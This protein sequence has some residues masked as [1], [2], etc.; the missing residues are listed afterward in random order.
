MIARM[1]A[2]TREQPDA[3]F[4]QLTGIFRNYHFPEMKQKHKDYVDSLKDKAEF[5]RLL[6]QLVLEGYPIEMYVC[7]GAYRDRGLLITMKNGLLRFYNNIARDILF[8]TLSNVFFSED[9]LIELSNSFRTWPKLELRSREYLQTINFESR[10]WIRFDGKQFDPF[11]SKITNACW[12]RFMKNYSRLD[13]AYVEW[14]DNDW[15][16][17]L[18]QASISSF[19]EHNRDFTRNSFVSPESSQLASLLHALFGIFDFQVSTI[20]DESDTIIDFEVTDSNDQSYRDRICI[21]YV[22]PLTNNEARISIASVFIDFITLER[23]R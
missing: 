14:N 18:F 23:R 6:G 5:Y 16:L 10:K 8:D 7:D 2:R 4:E 20:R 13:F 3:N 19:P 11:T 1:V 9:R 17:Y 22:T 21:L 12:V 15:R